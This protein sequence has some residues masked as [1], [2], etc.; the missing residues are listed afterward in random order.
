MV[1]AC[2]VNPG[3]DAGMLLG[4]R[5]AYTSTLGCS[6]VGMVGQP[7]KVYYLSRGPDEYSGPDKVSGVEDPVQDAK[8]GSRG[9]LVLPESPEVAG[10]ALPAR[11]DGADAAEAHLRRHP[12]YVS[13]ARI[14]LGLGGAGLLGLIHELEALTATGVLVERPRPGGVREWNWSPG[15]GVGV[16]RPAPLF[17]LIPPSRR[18]SSRTR[19]RA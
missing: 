18:W 14:G 5:R 19:T 17:S 8:S 16:T 11:G 1:P 9:I 15:R 12:G 10:V 13:A 7:K 6:L 4:S 3:S 2:A